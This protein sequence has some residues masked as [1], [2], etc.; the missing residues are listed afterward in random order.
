MIITKTTVFVWDKP[1]EITVHQKSKTV[2]I[3][4]GEYLGEQ[5]ESKGSSQ[6]VAA[7]HWREQA[8]YKG[9]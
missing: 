4:R 3:A 2:W 1:Y 5:L 9:N 6:T 8:R 7:A